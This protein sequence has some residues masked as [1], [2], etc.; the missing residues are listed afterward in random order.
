M[1]QAPAQGKQD[2]HQ[3]KQ[4]ANSNQYGEI[5]SLLVKEG[6]LTIKQIE[7]VQRIQ[8]KLPNPRPTINILKELKYVTD[9]ALW[10][11]IRKHHVSLKIGSLLVE[12]GI[13]TAEELEKAFQIQAEETPKRKIGEVLVAH[14][15]VDERKMIEVLSLQLGFPFVEPEFIDIDMRLF[16]RIPFRMYDSATFIPI[17]IEEDAAQVA[18]VDPTDKEDL[19]KIKKILN[20]EIVP[21]FALKNSIKEAIQKV[22]SRQ[23]NDRTKVSADSAVGIVNKLIIDALKEDISDIHIE[24][25]PDRLRIRFRRDGVLDI[26]RELGLEIIPT[27]T[28]RIKVMCGADITEKRRH[29]DARMVFDHAGHKLD[30]RISFFATVFGEKIVMRLLN[31]KREMVKLEDLGM[32]PKMLQRFN[33]DALDLPSG[34]ILVTGP[35]GSGKTTTVYSCID[36][37]NTPQTSI[38]T[39]EEPV[40]YVIPGIGQCSIDP[41]INLTFNETLRAMVRQDPDVI[42]IGEIRDTYSAEI[43]VQAAL[44]G[45]KVVT[46]FHT[47]DSIGGLVRL[48]NMNI[49]AFMI[50]STVVSV[51]AQRLMRKVCTECAEDYKPSIQDLRRLRYSAKDIHGANFKKGRGCSHCRHT[52]YKGRI[53]CFELLVLDEYVRNAIL[54]KKTSHE[55]RRTSIE[56][57]GLVT[58]L[59]EGIVKAAAGITSIEEVLHSAPRLLFPRPLNEIRRLVGA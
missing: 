55:I 58:L 28:S 12:L 14:R 37:L 51:L 19:S 23:E 25:L 20:I 13:L 41:K 26:Y 16:N 59:E 57:A 34:V 47:E 54:E 42:V 45:H 48:L 18:F 29:Q 7:Y 3:N 43:A 44:T 31:R 17:K 36:Y 27:L 8:S 9:E 46:T 30:L 21:C 11:T 53:A 22:I 49:E 10:S 2:N 6:I 15:F 56:T 39:A 4:N 33:N 35:T 5:L 40:E 52:G 24:P 1:L 32:Y 38:I 50:S